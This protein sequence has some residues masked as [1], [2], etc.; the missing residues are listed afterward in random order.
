[1]PN[2]PRPDTLFALTHSARAVDAFLPTDDEVRLLGEQ[3]YFLRRT[4]RGEAAARQAAAQV[5]TLAR[6]GLLVPAALSRGATR[7]HDASLRGDLTGWLT[8]AHTGP[9]LSALRAGFTALGEALNAQAYL[10]LGRHDVQLALYP[11]GGAR[12]VRH[13]DA[14]ASGAGSRGANRRLTAITYLNAAWEPAH[15]GCLRLFTD[16]G[17]VDVP[18]RLD[19]LVVFLSERLEHEVLPAFAPRLAATAWYYGRAE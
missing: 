3:G 17:E 19:T 5:D 2:A 6:A 14:F 10:G 15:G 8:P 9:G 16:A 1:V 12:Y 7:R 13:R 11:G 4:C 18:P